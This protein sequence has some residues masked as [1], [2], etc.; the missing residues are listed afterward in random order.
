MNAYKHDGFWM[1]MDN[2]RDKEYL[3]SLWAGGDAP[4]KIWQQ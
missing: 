2:I 4:W 3:E 1:P